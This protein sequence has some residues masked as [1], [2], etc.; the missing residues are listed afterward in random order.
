[1]KNPESMN[2][3]EIRTELINSHSYEPGVVAQLKGKQRLA[4][5]LQKARMESSPTEYFQ[6]MEIDRPKLET[7]FVDDSQEMVVPRIGSPDWQSYVM[8]HLEQNE[9]VDINGNLYP[10]TAGLRRIVQ[11]LLGDIVESGPIMIEA[12]KSSECADRAT[13]LYEVRIAWKQTDVKYLDLSDVAPADR[14]VRCFREAAD[15][16]RGNTKDTYAVHPVA[17]ASTRAE[18]RALKKALQLNLLVAE[19]MDN[20]KDASKFVVQQEKSSDGHYKDDEPASGAQLGTIKRLAKR[21]GI[22]VEKLLE[23]SCK[24]KAMSKIEKSE[25]GSLIELLNSYQAQGKEHQEIPESIK[26]TV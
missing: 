9:L 13:V 1:M 15:V 12:P 16:W 21:N 25:A 24:G 11:V 5:E 17:T 23:R 19:E 18:G 3:D 14:D 8:A 26:E 10:K 20:D 2:V 6:K 4:I 7:E 22:N